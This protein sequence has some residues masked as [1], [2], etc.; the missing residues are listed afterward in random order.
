[1]HTF[2]GSKRELSEHPNIV[3]ELGL[4][5]MSVFFRLFVG[6]GVG[7]MGLYFIVLGV[8]VLRDDPRNV[9]GAG[10]MGGSGLL[11]G[12]LGAGLLGAGLRELRKR[13]LLA[14]HPNE[15]WRVD[16][17]WEARMASDRA[18]GLV[19]PFA[20]AISLTL[21]MLILNGLLLVPEDVPPWVRLFVGGSSL[22]LL[23]MWRHAF[24]KLGQRRKYGIMRLRL[25]SFP[26]FIDQPLRVTAELPQALRDCSVKATLRYVEEGWERRGRGRDRGQ[27]LVAYERWAEVR[28]VLAEEKES[29]SEVSFNFQLPHGA[30]STE[31]SPMGARYWELQLDART[32]GGDHRALFLLPVYARVQA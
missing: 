23:P 5:S 14:R 18:Q 29:E 25:G 30:P 6:F 10:F 26:F 19:A 31:I 11:V 7:V 22:V 27:C 9:P 32:P 24:H 2:G 21:V 28:V 15:P 4:G 20:K 13:Q 8:L 12:A 3:P 1:M 16:H 17:D